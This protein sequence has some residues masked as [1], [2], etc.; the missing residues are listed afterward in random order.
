MRYRRNNA[1]H[2]YRGATLVLL[3]AFTIFAAQWFVLAESSA[4][5]AYWP[6]AESAPATDALD[7]AM[8]AV[9]A[10]R[11][12]DPLGSSTIDKMQ[13]RHSLPL[14]HPDVI[15][16]KLRAERLLPIAKY[17]TAEALSQL[18][19]ESGVRSLSSGVIATRLKKVNEIKPDV[20]LRDNA[21]VF[22]SDPQ[23]IRFGTI[24]LA[25][26]PSDE[27]MISVLAHELTHVADGPK[28]SLQF[29]FRRVAQRAA[30][31]VKFRISHL[32]AEEFTCDLVGTMTA[33]AY[34]A[35]TP[36]SEPLSRRA[37][38]ALEH[39]CVETDDTDN[40]HLSPRNTMRAI[41]AFNI[42]LTREI[43]GEVEISTPRRRPARGSRS[44]HSTPR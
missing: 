26:L 30:Q 32:R 22:N 10:E 34:I 23:A 44:A 33:R 35:R 9:C 1:C 12:A 21:S 27:A 36:N 8:I 18:A 13:A 25:G 16:G 41:L 43:T 7:R 28:S 39:N 24:F 20:E 15:A 40:V 38:R 11:E 14:H 29:F 6:G 37:A 31:F 42:D 4:H 5:F 3:I 2:L 17:L 19:R